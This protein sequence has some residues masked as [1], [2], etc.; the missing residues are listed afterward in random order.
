M[1]QHG[2]VTGVE[3]SAGPISADVVVLANGDW[4]VALAAALGVQ[5]PIQRPN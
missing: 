1:T 3:T 4:S 2:R 5:I